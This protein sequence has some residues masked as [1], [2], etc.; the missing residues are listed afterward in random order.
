LNRYHKLA[1]LMLINRP[2][3]FAGLQRNQSRKCKEEGRDKMCTCNRYSTDPGGF[4]AGGG[5]SRIRM[6]SA[7]RRPRDWDY[8]P[9][10]EQM[11]PSGDRWFIQ[12]VLPVGWVPFVFS[13][14]PPAAFSSGSGL[15]LELVLFCFRVLLPVV[16]LLRPGGSF[17]SSFCRILFSS[18]ITPS[19]HFVRLC[20]DGWRCRCFRIPVIQGSS[21]MPCS[22][23]GGDWRRAGGP[24]ETRGYVPSTSSVDWCSCW[25]ECLVDLY[26]GFLGVPTKLTDIL[27]C[28]CR[29]VHTGGV[30]ARSEPEHIGGVGTTSILV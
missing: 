8:R 27:C 4:D 1:N 11:C 5:G 17:H 7:A 25:C 3:K 16:F 22:D 13:G 2:C 28:R 18:L 21:G 12:K 15:S 30:V 26:R 10:A 20:P 29:L 24:V 9:C 6:A 14:A 23:L 19:S